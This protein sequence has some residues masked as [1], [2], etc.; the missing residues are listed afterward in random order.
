MKKILIILGLSSLLL[1]GEISTDILIKKDSSFNKK[2]AFNLK[3]KIVEANIKKEDSIES[4]LNNLSKEDKLRIGIISN[5][6]LLYYKNN[7]KEDLNKKI[8]MLMPLYDKSIY[9]FVDK[10]SNI[11]SLDD[12]NNKK[13]SIGTK[14]SNSW[15]VAQILKKE[16]KLNWSEKNNSLETKEDLRQIS[17]KLLTNKLDAFI[18]VGDKDENLI[19]EH[20]LPNA[21]KKLKLLEAKSKYFKT[22]EIKQK[23]YNWLDASSKKILYTKE[24]LVAHNFYFINGK[25]PNSYQNYET[26]LKMIKRNCGKHIQKTL[27]IDTRDFHGTTWDKWFDGGQISLRNMIN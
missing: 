14:N 15:F 20:F 17:F 26:K 2:I 13:V 5:E 21:G 18:Y 1:M 23:E 25:S 19:E 12:L 16:H 11:T 9:I 24:L 10:N 4:M 6:A 27:K 22:K 8:K 7:G 3:E